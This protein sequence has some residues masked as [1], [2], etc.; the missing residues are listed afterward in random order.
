MKNALNTDAIKLER[1]DNAV[2][3]HPESTAEIVLPGSFPLALA[4]FARD[5]ADLILRTAPP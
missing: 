3:I 5:G 1:P 2:V 4:D